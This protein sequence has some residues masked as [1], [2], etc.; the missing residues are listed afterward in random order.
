[1]N[2][3]FNSQLNKSKK[4]TAPQLTCYGSVTQLTTSGTDIMVEAIVNPPGPGCS[5]DTPHMVCANP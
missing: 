4:Y 3:S 5:Q 1:M 2:T